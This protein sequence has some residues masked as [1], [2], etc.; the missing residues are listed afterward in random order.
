[1]LLYPSNPQAQGCMPCPLRNFNQYN[2]SR[3]KNQNPLT[4]KEPDFKSFKG[5]AVDFYHSDV[6]K[7]DIYMKLQTYFPGVNKLGQL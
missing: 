3:V 6:S 5:N 2:K 7:I 1:M 4:H